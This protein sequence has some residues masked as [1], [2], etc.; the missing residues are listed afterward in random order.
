[1]KCWNSAFNAQGW[2]VIIGVIQIGAVENI[3]GISGGAQEKGKTGW[4]SVYSPNLLE[5]LVSVLVISLCKIF[6]PC[7]AFDAILC[8]NWSFWPPSCET[9]QITL[10]G[11]QTYNIHCQPRQEVSELWRRRQ[12]EVSKRWMKWKVIQW[13][14]LEHLDH[15]LPCSK[16]KWSIYK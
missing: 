15:F 14:T 9:L 6:I 1:M 5:K 2:G 11:T 4:N 12:Q 16:I 10:I 8:R 7:Y 13:K 3:G